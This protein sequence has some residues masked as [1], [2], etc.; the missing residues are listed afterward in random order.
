ME[1]M[2]LPLKRY[3]DFNGRS[4]RREFWMFAALHALVAL[5]F[6]VPLS[7]IFFRG[8]AG[9][10]P[11]TLGVIV[12]LL[13]LYVA[14]MFVPGLAVQVRRFHDLG[15][16]GWMVLIGFVPVVGVFAILYFMCLPGT[17]G[18]NRYGADP[19]AEDVAIRP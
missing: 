16:P 1:W 2:L 12:P 4:S 19:V 13:G 10:L 15:R 8:M 6:Y 7:G 3:A 17:S 14:V 5:L 9:V 18:P 11:A